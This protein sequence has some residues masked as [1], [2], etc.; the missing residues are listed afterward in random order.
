MDTA[1][2]PP[3]QRESVV[4]VGAAPLGPGQLVMMN[5]APGEGPF[6]TCRRARV[7]LEGKG[8]PL[9]LGE[10]AVLAP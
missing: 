8:S 1:V 10:Q 2:V 7:V 4:D 6:A 5:L 9:V 3:A